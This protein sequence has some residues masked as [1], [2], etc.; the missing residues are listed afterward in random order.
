[1]A[2]GFEQG[3]QFVGGDHIDAVHGKDGKTGAAAT[4][5]VNSL[6]GEAKT[7]GDHE[8]TEGVGQVGEARRAAQAFIFADIEKGEMATLGQKAREA[9]LD[10]ALLE[11]PLQVRR[12]Q[13]GTVS[14]DEIKRRVSQLNAGETKRF[15]RDTE[16]PNRGA[17]AVVERVAKGAQ[18]DVVEK[19]AGATQ[20]GAHLD[21]SHFRPVVDAPPGGAGSLLKEGGVAEGVRLRP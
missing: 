17:D 3:V 9:T 10:D 19:S 5:L 18:V 1:M 15:Q 13:I 21:V 8:R 16:A 14:R 11:T 7:A 2:E 12:A 4:N 6:T 20:N